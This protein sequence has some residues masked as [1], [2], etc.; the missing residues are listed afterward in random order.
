MKRFLLLPGLVAL[1]GTLI[2]S[3]PELPSTFSQ[4]Q[5][6]IAAYWHRMAERRHREALECFTRAV[7]DDAEMMLALPKLVELRCIDFRVGNRD[8]GRADVFY[9]VE[10][11]VA[12]TD[13]LAHF[14]T[15]DRLHLTNRGWKIDRPLQLAVKGG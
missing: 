3:T 5:Q 13:P 15:G 7:P 8:S 4:P 12:L 2:D 11:R 1:C 10:Y 6:T 9:T 14:E